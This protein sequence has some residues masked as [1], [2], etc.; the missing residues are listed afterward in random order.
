MKSKNNLFTVLF[1][2][3]IK[4]YS[5]GQ[6]S[7]IYNIGGSGADYLTLEQAVNDLNIQGISNSVTFKLNPGNYSGVI[8]SEIQGTS[9]TKTFTLQS[10][11]LN[12]SDV[13]INGT[14]IFN[15]ASFITINALTIN[16]YK[17]IDFYKSN[18]IFIKNCTMNS[19]YSAAE[20]GAINIL[21]FWQDETGLSRITIDS[22]TINTGRPSIYCIA[23]KG[24]TTISNCVINTTG[25]VS[26]KA[27]SSDYFNI[28][29]SYIYGGIDIE[30]N[31]HSN[32]KNNV[33][34]GKINAGKIDSVLNNTFESN[35]ELKISSNFYYRNN[36]P[37][38]QL[39][40]S[41][42]GNNSN[43]K[44]IENNI[45]GSIN[46]NFANNVIFTGNS[47][48]ANISLSFNKNLL[49]NNNRMLGNLSYS[50]TSSSPSSNYQIYN[51]IF[52]GSYVSDHV[53][54]SKI[55]YNN[56]L[57]NARLELAYA[58]NQISNNNFCSEIIGASSANNISSNNYFPYIY[59]PYD[60]NAKCYNPEYQS[61]SSGLSTNPL[62]QGKGITS[63]PYLDFLGQIRKHP[64]AIGANEILIYD[65]LDYNIF[66]PCGEELNI[67]Y[68]DF[69]DNGYSWW[70]PDSLIQNSETSYPS[71]SPNINTTFYLNN[72]ILGIID[73]ISVYIDSFLVE[74]SDIPTVYC[75]FS[76]QLIAN[77]H[78][79]ANYEWSP[80]EGLSNSHIRNPSLLL[81]NSNNL[82]YIVECNVPGCGISFDTLNIDFDPLPYALIYYPQIS[83]DT[84]L[85]S[86]YNT[87]S[88]SF[89]WDFG[90]GT[91]SNEE[92]PNHVYAE[93]GLYT[94]TL[95]VYNSYGSYSTFVYYYNYW[96]S[97]NQLE[98][99][100]ITIYPNPT[101][102][103]IYICGLPKNDLTQIELFDFSGNLIF[104]GKINKNDSIDIEKLENGVYILKI[105]HD[106]ESIYRKIVKY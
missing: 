100:N 63:I 64:A 19:G 46:I 80:Q 14:I 16:N 82:Q 3:L 44:F 89:L 22:C 20:E 72:S 7:G 85:F 17:V 51:N 75:G 68:N 25:G 40:E 79:N 48:L 6:L 28:N 35:E 92:N 70:S 42:P 62:L 13:I 58:D 104:K 73:S 47:I 74:I 84:S 93:N 69:P 38:Q 4:L 21:H 11:T 66:I 34:I 97:S 76:A 9:N 29:N 30:T 54:G 86:S 18:Y 8:F 27:N 45:Q 77:Y 103:K 57:N 2:L 87:C 88:D 26:I 15:Q 31:S 36:F 24:R 41:N 43:A 56:F 5:F 101:S 81:E 65:S 94:V 23:N 53:H 98:S 95:S 105:S 10:S 60:I 39:N 61:D 55:K 71:L 52:L 1:L 83:N 33:I 59:T 12:S 91:F 106:N 78:A 67:N 96:L 102:D 90:D 99:E 37:L 32:L 50:N 49:F